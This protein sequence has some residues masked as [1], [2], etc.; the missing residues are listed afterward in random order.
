MLGI[1]IREDFWT[2]LSVEALKREWEHTGFEGLLYNEQYP[3]LTHIKVGGCV[4]DLLLSFYFAV[5][6]RESLLTLQRLGQEY[7]VLHSHRNGQGAFV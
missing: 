5:I 4:I 7:V 3:S 6:D 1:L 2:L